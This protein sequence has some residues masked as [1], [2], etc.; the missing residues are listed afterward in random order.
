[1]KIF[2]IN[3]VRRSD[4]LN[5]M[6]AQLNRLSLSF[7]RVSAID[8][9][10]VNDAWLQ[11]HFSSRGP[12]GVMSKGDKCCLISHQRAW[13]AFLASGDEYGVVLEDDVALDASAEELLRNDKWIP[14]PLQLLKL[15]HFGPMGQRVLIGRNTTLDKG[16]KVAEIHSR[17]TGAAA[18]I[19]NRQAAERM[20]TPGMKWSVAVDHALFNPNVSA[21]AQRL[22]PHQLLPVIARQTP[23]LGGT[24][25]IGEWRAEQRRLSWTYVRREL[26]RAYYEVRLLPQQIARL[27]T[28]RGAFVR[29]RNDAL[30]RA[31]AHPA[32]RHSGV[33]QAEHNAA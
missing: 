5:A 1:M 11:Q 2:L 31:M 26:V 21:L 24:T 17:H 10:T 19:I 15:E 16:R 13:A 3:L 23:A 8:A 30:I 28:G 27:V 4:R 6:A 18:Y 33:G 20:L 9:L 32:R 14:R 22:R 12:L 29:V 7:K 25:D